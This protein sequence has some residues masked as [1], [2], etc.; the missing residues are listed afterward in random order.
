VAERPLG[1]GVV[2]TG[3]VAGAHADNFR[4]TAGTRVVAVCSRF[5]ANARRFIAEKG[6]AD[7]APFDDLKKFLAVKELDVVVLATPHD[8]HPAETIAAAKA[9]KH[10]V[11]E[12]PV[13]LDPA[14]LKQMVAAVNAAGVLTSVCFEL[15]WSGPSN[16][17]RCS[18]RGFSAT[19]LRRGGATAT[20][21]GRGTGSGPGTSRRSSAARPS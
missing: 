7:A 11:I 3:W 13:A 6:L 14:A 21:A 20:A 10:V 16:I 12:K 15:R 8:R 18:R 4:R 17:G 9:G 5:E 2:G 1:I 19:L